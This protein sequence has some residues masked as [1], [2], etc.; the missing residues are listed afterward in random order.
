MIRRIRLRSLVSRLGA[1]S[2]VVQGGLIVPAVHPGGGPYLILRAGKRI[3]GPDR[4]LRR[5]AREVDYSR[6]SSLAYCA[7]RLGAA[8]NG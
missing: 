6:F 2:P 4:E 1:G 7:L 8:Q 3:D 5:Q